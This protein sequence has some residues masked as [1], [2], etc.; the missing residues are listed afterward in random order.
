MRI[1]LKVGLL[2]AAIVCAAFAAAKAQE[3]RSYIP[4]SWFQ[5]KGDARSSETSAS[6]TAAPKAQAARAAHRQK[7]VKHARIGVKRKRVAV[8]RHHRVRLV[9][10]RYHPRHYRYSRYA[11]YRPAYPVFPFGLFNW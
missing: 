2:A 5:E 7:T 9:Y 3:E 10:Y 1:R 11:Y 8:Y 6:Q 4:P